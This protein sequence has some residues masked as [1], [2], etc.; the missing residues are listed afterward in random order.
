M[1]EL[2]VVL[3]EALQSIEQTTDLFYQQKNDEGYQ[4]LDNTLNI[5][6]KAVNKI[7]ENKIAGY[8]LE[9]EEN[10][11]I[12]VLTEAMKAIEVKDTVL[13]SDILQFELKEIFN[14]L[15]KTI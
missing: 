14:T 8:N 12:Q 7:F 6:T 1:E 10:Q 13:F 9:I 11:I 2:K 5:L 4:K 3:E 15:L